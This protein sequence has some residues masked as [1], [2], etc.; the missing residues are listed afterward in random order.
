MRWVNQKL[1]IIFIPSKENS[2]RPKF[3][4]SQT[5]FYCLISLL[6]LKLFAVPFFLLLQKNIFFAAIVES[7][8]IKFNNQYRHSLNLPILK[9]NPQLK[10]AA[11]LKAKDILE[12]DYFSHYSPEGISPWYWLE[13]AGYKYKIA[14]ENLAIGFLDSEEVYRAWMD[15]PSHRANLLNPNFQEVGIGVLKGNFQGNETTVVVQFFASPAVLT[16]SQISSP[17]KIKK[18]IITLE[19]KKEIAET[20]KEIK[21]KEK[22]EEKEVAPVVSEPGVEKLS[23]SSL[24]PTLP[25]EKLVFEFL[26]FL[27]SDYHKLLQMVTYGFLIL[28]IVALLINIFVRFNIQH[29]DLIF[30][31]IGF[32]IL[33]IIFVMID[34]TDIIKIISPN[35][36]IY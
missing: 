15:S 6:L 12:K 18:E 29:P 36:I 26:S 17:L 13:T 16:S 14:G 19:E 4:E 1:K 8:L 30:K 10:Q 7:A 22:I 5:L 31:T 32:I 27:A 24:Q 28:I 25:R 11:L 23:I 34:K 9:E 3:L 35:L 21:E 2:Y 20:K 33:L